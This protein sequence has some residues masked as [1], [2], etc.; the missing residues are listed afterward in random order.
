M[1][2]ILFINCIRDNK[3]AF[4]KKLIDISNKLNINPDWLMLVFYIETAAVKT[5][6]IN[7]Q[8]KNPKTNAVGLIK[9]M[10]ATAKSLGTSISALL[11]MS[12]VEQLD[13]V[14]KYLRPYSGKIKS[15]VDCYLAVFFPV[16]IGRPVGWTIETKSLPAERIAKYNPL[17]DLNKDGKITVGEIEQTV[18]SFIPKEAGL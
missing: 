8:A 12:N 7:H 4:T 15:L 5:K 16:A 14:L 6:V 9:F 3:E 17:Y 1:N 13:Y 11:Q 2:N 18:K 10:P